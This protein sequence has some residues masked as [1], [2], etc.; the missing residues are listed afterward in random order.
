MNRVLRHVLI[1]LAF[2]VLVPC[3][4]AA[5][6]SWG[7]DW[8]ELRNWALG[9]DKKPAAVSR[10]APVQER[11]VSLR[12]V[13]RQSR[14]APSIPA[15]KSRAAAPE[16][17]TIPSAA[18]PAARVT[19]TVTP[20]QASLPPPR[21]RSRARAPRGEPAPK[22]EPNLFAEQFYIHPAQKLDYVTQ[23]QRGFIFVEEEALEGEARYSIVTDFGGSILKTRQVPDITSA[24]ELRKW[25]ETN[26]EVATFE[27]VEIKKLPFVSGEG[28]PEYRYW[29]GNR[30][31]AAVEQ[32]KAEIALIQSVA[33]T[34]GKDFRQMVREAQASAYIAEEPEAV[35]IP[36][37]ANFK[38]EEELFLKYLDQLDIGEKMFGPF[39]GEPSGEPITWQ[40]FGETTFR[41]TN[42]TQ[43]DFRNQFGFYTNR[44][45]FKGI[46]APL[47]TIDPFIEATLAMESNGNDGGSHLD[48]SAGL[49]WRPLSRNEWFLNFR[50]GGI[51]L[52]EW[53]RNYRFYV[54]YFDRK[55]IKG[56]ILNA[57]DYDLLAGV[58]IFYEWG[59]ELPPVTET[60]PPEGVTEFLR[61][62]A[63]GEYFGNYRYEMTNFGTE[64]DFGA[65]I[66]NSSVILGIKLPGIPLPENPINEQLMLM[67]YM[68]FEHVNN[69]KFSFP[70]QN[71]YFVAAG[72]R[73]MPFLDYRYK[74]NEWLAKTKLF[75]EYVGVGLVQ[76][77][78][79][80][81]E[82][83]NAVR[84]DFRIGLSIS[85]KRF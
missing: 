61:R 33:L 62:Y 41:T 53:V 51:P 46:R 23:E 43:P 73:W 20:P 57:K 78:K 4:R 15:A 40:S 13:E 17:V 68:R 12:E 52:L 34:Q 67:P 84:H 37:P 36:G 38:K 8:D 66:L 29:V 55:N 2:M 32:A 35:E 16:G 70:Y 27:E 14:A 21:S 71:Q 3:A 75:F 18:M 76:H 47:S 77:A 80:D 65:I 10:P 59:V 44:L 22:P 50:P 83:P 42:L 69:T 58:Q 82:S 9:P 19:T 24:S 64:D 39:T 25:I 54:Q 28:V 48:L 49:E 56:E 11:A 63:W 31:Y 79:Q 7:G 26:L 30:S 60:G 74:E 85:Q 5:E 45:V 6:D 81:S 1:I 72:V